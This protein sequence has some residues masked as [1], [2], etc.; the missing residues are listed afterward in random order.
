MREASEGKM[1][2]GWVYIGGDLGGLDSR[3]GGEDLG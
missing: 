3:G 1:S 2:D